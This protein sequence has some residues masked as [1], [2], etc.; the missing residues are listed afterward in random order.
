MAELTDRK[1]QAT[2]PAPADDQWL[3]DGGA[4]GEGRLML[5]IRAAN[6][7]G[8]KSWYFRYTNSAGAREAI[9]IGPYAPDGDAK[10]RFSLVQARNR[11]RDWSA[12][13]RAGNR[14]LKAYFDREQ[15]ARDSAIR[16]QE[17]AEQQA[18]ED[19]KRGT[20]QALI[21]AYCAYLEKRKAQSAKDA[22]NVLTRNVLKEYPGVAARRAKDLTHRDLLPVLRRLVDAGKGRTAAKVRSYL[23]AAYQM[24]L[25]AE[26]DAAI[27]AELLGFGLDHNPASALAALT[28]FSRAGTRE[29]SAPELRQYLDAVDK[30]EN[31]PIRT[32]LQMAI[33]LG[34]QRPQQLIRAKA[35][36]VDLAGRTLTLVDAKGARQHPRIHVL[37]LTDNAIALLQPMMALNSTAPS[38]FSTD[39]E[40]VPHIS[41]LSTT[42]SEISAAL[43][44]AE[45]I[46]APFLMRDLRRTTET[47]LA[48]CGV[49]KN[50]RA[51]LLSHGI[52]GVQARHYDRYSYLK[53]KLQALQTW[54]R[55]LADIR[56][57]EPSEA[58]VVHANFGHSA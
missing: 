46:R 13:Y 48:G 43:V 53:E 25:E 41:T 17:A 36:D 4:R 57:G 10:A 40:T 27:P 14:D 37:P 30:L 58:K 15:R 24:A 49:S 38:L 44:K 21:T 33:L 42:V 8:S 47:M 23:H 26:T 32:A 35:A 2:K 28:K 29:L 20:L 6:A 9:W 3:S 54:E 34:G 18:A 50:I 45:K 55:H 22:K 39:G 5:R 7:G 19:A 56:R 31:V 11:A 12:I 16:A 1:I 51:Q 52:S